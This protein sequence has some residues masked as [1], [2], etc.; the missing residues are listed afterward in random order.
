MDT[1]MIVLNV[2][3]AI[4]LVAYIAYGILKKKRIKAAKEA[5]KNS[6]KRNVKS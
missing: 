3:S 6:K 1:I 5:E 2:I 4:I